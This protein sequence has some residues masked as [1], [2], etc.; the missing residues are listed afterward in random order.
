MA[1]RYKI[2]IEEGDSKMI[3]IGSYV[4]IKEGQKRYMSY[5]QNKVGIVLSI[6]NGGE[7]IKI[8]WMDNTYKLLDIEEGHNCL[9]Y[10]Y[11]FEEITEEEQFK[12]EAAVSCREKEIVLKLA[13][14]PLYKIKNEDMEL[15]LVRKLKRIRKIAKEIDTTMHELSPEIMAMAIEVHCGM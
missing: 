11:N 3:K 2:G 8:R 14:N 13:N 9:F 7:S 6:F 4:K 5:Y 12:I 15:F 10:A 1:V